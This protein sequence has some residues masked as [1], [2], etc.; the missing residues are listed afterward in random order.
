MKK[1]Y[2]FTMALAFLLGGI[3][4]ILWRFFNLKMGVVIT[5]IALVPGFVASFMR[6]SARRIGILDFIVDRVR[7][8]NNKPPYK[9]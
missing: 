3:G 6:P 4:F 2:F 8:G 5:V 7:N 1:Y 9:D